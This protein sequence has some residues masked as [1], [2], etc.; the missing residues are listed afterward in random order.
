MFG[1]QARQL[2]S[3]PLNGAGWDFGL[4]H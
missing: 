4:G 1:G 2:A 3:P